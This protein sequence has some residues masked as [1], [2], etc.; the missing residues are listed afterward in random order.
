MSQG[1]DAKLFQRGKIQ[2][3]NTALYAITTSLMQAHDSTGVSSGAAR[4]GDQRQEVHKK[5]DSIEE[6]RGKYH[7]GQ[8]Q[9]VPFVP[10]LASAQ[11]NSQIT[12]PG[13]CHR[14]SRMSYNV[15]VLPYL[16]SRRVELIQSNTYSIRADP[17]QWSTY[18]LSVTDG[19]NPTRF[20]S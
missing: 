6:D 15:W 13:Q 18:S 3:R 4:S 14:Y 19:Q 20:T 7:H 8:R 10:I 9:S 12:V 16:K 11:R 2:V 5:E 1:Q 17:I